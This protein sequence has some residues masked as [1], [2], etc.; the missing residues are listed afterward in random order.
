MPSLWEDF[1][2]LKDAKIRFTVIITFK[3]YSK[4]LTSVIGDAENAAI[5]TKCTQALFIV[6][7]V[8]PETVEYPQWMFIFSPKVCVFVL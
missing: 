2:S 1:L 7:S 4:K 8:S 6:W 5:V 3:K